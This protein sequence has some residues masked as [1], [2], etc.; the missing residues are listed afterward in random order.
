[1]TSATRER[2]WPLGVLSHRPIPLASDRTVAVLGVWCRN[3]RQAP[4]GDFTSR[5]LQATIARLAFQRPLAKR[6]TNY[7]FLHSFARH[8]LAD[9]YDI[10]A[11]QE[12]LG[13]SDAPTRMMYTHVLNRGARALHSPDQPF[14]APIRSALRRDSLSR[15][16][17]TREA[18]IR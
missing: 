18:R 13:H 16:Q 2:P 9:T 10:R 17:K 8:L 15:R 6:V 4:R 1:M 7:T 5:P 14:G 12:V 3:P 11:L